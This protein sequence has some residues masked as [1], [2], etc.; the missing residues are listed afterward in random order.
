MRIGVAKIDQGGD[1]GIKLT[2]KVWSNGVGHRAEIDHG[3]GML[4][5]TDQNDEWR[6]W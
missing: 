6:R 5:E 2:I 4:K 3:K 1:K